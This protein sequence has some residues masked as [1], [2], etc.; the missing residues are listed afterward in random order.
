M[1]FD[2]HVV[3]ADRLVSA[4]P[5]EEWRAADSGGSSLNGFLAF[6]VIDRCVRLLRS[7]A[8]TAADPAGAAAADR[9]AAEADVARAALIAADAPG[10]PEARANASEL[11]WRAAATLAAAHGARS[12]LLSNHAQRLA[13]EAAFT[14]VFGSRPTIRDALLKRL[15]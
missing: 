15:A 11:A 1:T 6:G 12:V 5:F 8:D 14:L 13:R 3:P 10:T 9:L 4:L 2:G 7:I